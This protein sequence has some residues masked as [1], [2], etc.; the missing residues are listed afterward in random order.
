MEMNITCS[1]DQVQVDLSGAMYVEDAAI[2]RESLLSHL[3]KGNKN[4]IIKMANLTYIDSS[5][6]GVL[7][8]IHKRAQAI[9]GSVVL[10]GTQGMV[11]ELFEVSRLHHVFEMR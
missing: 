8:G 2:M 4:F 9:A 11:K 6:L 1:N 7:V 3:E 10:I 5:G